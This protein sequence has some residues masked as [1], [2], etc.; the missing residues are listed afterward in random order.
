M[1]RDLG[2]GPLR[3]PISLKNLML[4]SH[5]QWPAMYISLLICSNTKRLVT[6]SREEVVGVMSPESYHGQ[7]LNSG[8]RKDQLDTT[9]M[10]LDL[11]FLLS[12]LAAQ[13]SCILKLCCRGG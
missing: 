6:S 7:Y 9:M 10:C 13:R 2:C 4:C 1:S 8:P 3:V 5:S 12:A 11:G